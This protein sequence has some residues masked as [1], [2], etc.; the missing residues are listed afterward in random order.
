MFYSKYLLKVLAISAMPIN[1][2]KRC[3]IMKDV[4]SRIMLAGTFLKKGY[5][6]DT[7]ELKELKKE[8]FGEILHLSKYEIKILKKL[9]EDE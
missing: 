8:I 7:D 4:R 1:L 9:L 2:I 3:L 6:M 5:S